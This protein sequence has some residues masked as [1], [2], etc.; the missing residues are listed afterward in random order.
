MF[1]ALDGPP[2]LSET[3]KAQFS[4]EST[5]AAIVANLP[6]LT[7]AIPHM[8]AAELK[9]YVEAALRTLRDKHDGADILKIFS[10]MNPVQQ[11]MVIT[12]GFPQGFFNFGPTDAQK[13]RDMTVIAT[14][15]ALGDGFDMTP[16]LRLN[17]HGEAEEF[18]QH[19]AGLLLDRLRSRFASIPES[20]SAATSTPDGAKVGDQRTISALKEMD[21]YI[22]GLEDNV[23]SVGD[24]AQLQQIDLQ[25]A[26]Q[27]NQ[28]TLQMMSNLTKVLHDTA[29]AVIRNDN[30]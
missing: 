22:Q 10:V 1:A 3:Q 20:S 25:D 16:Y 21:A 12:D 15:N 11:L 2:S 8:N 27:K 17:H 7:D 18:T 24:D 23:N 13:L 29:M 26:L 14:M 4:T 5:Q 28:Q 9:F 6:A 19:T 30:S